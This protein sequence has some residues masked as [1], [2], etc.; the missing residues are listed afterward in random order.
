MDEGI[1]SYYEHRYMKTKYPNEKLTDN[2][3][4]SLLKF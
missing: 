1:N 3:P 4:K 2:I